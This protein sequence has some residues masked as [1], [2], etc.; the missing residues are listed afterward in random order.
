MGAFDGLGVPDGVLR[1]ADD[2]PLSRGDRVVGELRNG[3]R[4]TG[5]ITS[6][7]KGDIV[8]VHNELEG[9]KRSG[10]HYRFSRV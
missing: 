5:P 8:V 6:I 4:V 1:G 7:V 3:R 9:R 2:R 10:K